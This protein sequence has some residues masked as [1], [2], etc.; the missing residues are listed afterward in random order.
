VVPQLIPV[1]VMNNGQACVAQTRI[2]ASRSRYDEVVEA[3]TAAM[4][5]LKVGDPTD[6]DT[7]VG[8]LISERQR[9]RVEGYIAAGSDEGAKVTTGGGRPD[10]LDRGWYVEPTLFANVDNSMR[11]A[12]EEIFGPVLVAIPYEDQADAVRI[13]NDSDYGL[14]GSVWTTDIDNGTDVARGVRTGT[15]SVNNYAMAWSAPFG[16][17]KNS[18][19]GRELGPEGLSEYLESKTI[20]LPAGT[21]PTL[22]Y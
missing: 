3:L 10:G 15:Y 17:F 22:K 18:G 13:A 21:E 19:V 1:S 20:N 16:G 14:S 5:E 6:F 7:A 11:I 8:P 2:L 12:Q 9:D 4:S